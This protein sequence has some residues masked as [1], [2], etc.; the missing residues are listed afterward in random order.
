MPRLTNEQLNNI[1]VQ[2]HEFISLQVKTLDGGNHDILSILGGML[3]TVAATSLLPE[4][5]KDEAIK[6]LCGDV[7]AIFWDTVRQRNL[8]K[9]ALLGDTGETENE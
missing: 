9:A 1:C 6:E 2:T 3:A 4:A 7:T 5:D 8:E